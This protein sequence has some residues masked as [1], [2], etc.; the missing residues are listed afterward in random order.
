MPKSFRI[1]APFLSDEERAQVS[2]P[3]GLSAGM[4][5]TTEYELAILLGLQDKPV[6]P[7]VVAHETRGRHPS[8]V[9]VYRNRLRN[10]AARRSR[11]LNRLA[12]QR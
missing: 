12:A 4:R 6:F 7:G 1:T 9:T 3:G 11:R 8:D 2:K 10:R 5:Q